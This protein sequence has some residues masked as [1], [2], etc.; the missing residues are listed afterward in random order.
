MMVLILLK[1]I[2]I[3][4]KNNVKKGYKFKIPYFLCV[5]LVFNGLIAFYISRHLKIIDQAT[6]T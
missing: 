4:F 2:A 3:N 6:S 5:Y 1:T